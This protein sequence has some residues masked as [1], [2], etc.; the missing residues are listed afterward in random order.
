MHT[1][2]CENCKN[3]WT[4]K[5][6]LKKTSTLNPEMICPYCGKKQ[7]QTQKSKMKNT[8][9]IFVISL[10][11]LLQIFFSIPGIVLF[12]L[13]PILFMVVLFAYPFFI[14][15]SSTEGFIDLTKSK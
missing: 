2:T 10:P 15:L 14:R 3:K 7:Y 11:L 13:F 6:T 12:S 9:L 5:Q 8:F 1:P 4:W